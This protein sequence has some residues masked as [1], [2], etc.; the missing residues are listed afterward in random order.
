MAGNEVTARAGTALAVLLALLASTAGATPPWEDRPFEA[1]PAEVVKAA[2]Q[3]AGDDTHDVVILLEEGRFTFDAQ[4]RCDYRYRMVYRLQTEAGAREWATTGAAWA[5]WYEERP[6]LRSRVSTPDGR[7]HLLDP[8]T[9]AEV[10]VGEDDPAVFSD[11]RRLRAPLPAVMVG[12]VV[13]E[14]VRTVD[15]I[16]FFEA[17]SNH[18]FY[19]GSSVPVRQVRVVVDAPEGLP[20]HHVLRGLDGATV[21]RVQAAGRIRLTLESGPL[22]PL[23]PSEGWM[24]A[25]RMGHPYLAFST[26]ASWA[27]VATAYARV[28]DSRIGV[29]A[30]PQ[31][32]P[33][34]RREEVAA[35]LVKRLHEEIRYTGI[36]FGEAAIVPH[37]P[38][39]VL[40][41]RYGD[42]KD[43]SAFLVSRLREEGIPAYLALLDSGPGADVD[44]G[45][46]GMG[47]FDHAIVALPGE[48]TLWIDA[49]E[50]FARVNELPA[51]VQGRMA[52]VAA[53][54]TTGLVRT[55]ASAS[56]ANVLTKTREYLLADSGPG[57]VIETTRA[58][59]LVERAYRS[60]Y[61]RTDVKALREAHAKYVQSEHDASAVAKAEN[62]SP[63]DLSTAFSVRLESKDARRA[64]TDGTAAVVSIDPT[65]VLSRLPDFVGADP[66]DG[67]P[68]APR[69]EPFVL[70]EP[71]RVEWMYR[72]VP[73]AGFITKSLPQPVKTSL[74]TASLEMRFETRTDGVV[75]G[76]L[77]F[78]T[79]PPTLEPPAFKGLHEGVREWRKRAPL[80]VEFQ[81]RAEALLAAGRTC[82]A[83]ADRRQAALLQPRRSGPRER[84][85]LALLEAG[86]A[87]A[88]RV[89]ARQAVAADPA[90]STAQRTLGWVLEH[91]LVGRRFKTGSDIAGAEAAYLKAKEL[92]PKNVL[93]RSSLAILYQHDERGVPFGEGARLADAVREGESLR[94]D[95][96]VHGLDTN[97]MLSLMHLR[98]FEALETLARSLPDGQNRNDLLLAALAVRQ[99]V[100]AAIAEA[101]QLFPDASHRRDSLLRAGNSLVKLRLY[102]EG[103][104][105][106]GESAGGAPDAAARRARA[107][108]F[109]RVR[110]YEEQILDEK[111]PR[112]P[113]K[114]LLM[115]VTDY[116]LGVAG[117]EAGFLALVD[118]SEEERRRM[119]T[120]LPGLRRD[121]ARG[122]RASLGDT[123]F[124]RDLMDV[125]LSLTEF[126]VDGDAEGGFRVRLRAGERSQPFFVVEREGRRLVLTATPQEEAMAGEAWRLLERGDAVRAWR[127]LDWVREALVPPQ[128]NDPLAGSPFLRLWR[129]EGPRT[130]DEARVAAASLFSSEARLKQGVPVLEAWRNGL[131]EE[132]AARREADT[133]L[134]AVYAR[135]E[136]H[137]DVLRTAE[138]LAA[139]YPGSAVVAGLRMNALADLGRL[140]EARA[141]VQE[142][143]RAQP[144]DPTG[145]RLSTAL[146]L[147]AGEYEEAERAFARLAELGRSE[148]TDLNN[149]AWNAA[150]RGAVDDPALEWGRQSAQEGVG[151]TANL[152]TLATLYAEKGRV[153]EAMQVLGQ[154]LAASAEDEVRPH[155]WY[156]VGRL[157][158]HCGLPEVARQT[159]TRAADQ[160][161]TRLDSTAVLARRGLS[162][163]PAARR[164]P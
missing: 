100:P 97:L 84:L 115:E 159:Y 69:R 126:S 132:A 156:V 163:L 137:A 33:G 146:S 107:D 49:T 90:S 26:G 112:T 39:Q 25:D 136:R 67:G 77:A 28:V 141:L 154:S 36:E 61:S 164:R 76:R 133:A 29:P 71:H 150:L 9:V 87:E 113:V 93:A 31:L 151:R 56:G 127:W 109:A 131:P 11:R 52:L 19:V 98:R 51:G 38:A 34:V 144:D 157:A 50:E 96:D 140:P 57:R 54:E 104:A 43:K 14:E 60:Y 17:G 82:E 1:D 122:V 75:E 23:P 21:D 143:L 53:P 86:F 5:P 3:A 4:G 55:P 42:C 149:R 89:E 44:L 106:L 46:P 101:G 6:E 27:A 85:A 147:R 68:S 88:A 94:A 45:L 139:V 160:K 81:E 135:G 70:S 119:E 128:G 35:R 110:R 63:R 117:P 102:K 40:A 62:T 18:R 123:P 13:E 103:A 12:A 161:E 91:D 142:M 108:L 30:P 118:T 105:L 83:V 48:P 10:P 80:T 37:P 24:P 41:R 134:L 95:L 138:R 120:D 148:L 74:G 79:G 59:G 72:I 8:A 145:L 111:D 66:A 99:G 114:R 116:V 15:R 58:T 22:A 7:S 155:D 64:Q 32:R 130:A 92:D 16:P 121:V 2:A 125:V 73:P 153:K 65:A 158:E 78:D 129:P 124:S 152:H 20:L 47:R 162:R